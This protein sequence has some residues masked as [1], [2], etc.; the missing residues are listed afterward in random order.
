MFHLTSW[1]KSYKSSKLNI[2]LCCMLSFNDLI[3]YPKEL[4]QRFILL[5]YAQV[6]YLI[7]GSGIDLFR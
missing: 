1:E 2:E 5:P 3:N 4:F 6:D 7:N